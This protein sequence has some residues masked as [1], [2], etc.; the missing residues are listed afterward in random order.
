MTLIAWYH[1][2]KSQLLQRRGI[3]RSYFMRRA[4]KEKKNFNDTDSKKEN[5]IDEQR[6]AIDKLSSVNL[7]VKFKGPGR[8]GLERRMIGCNLCLF[9]KA[10][11]ANPEC[12]W[13]NN[14]SISTLPKCPLNL[15]RFS[16]LQHLRRYAGGTTLKSGA[17]TYCML[18]TEKVR[19]NY[20]NEVR[21]EER[22]SFSF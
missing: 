13:K 17:A 21:L 18:T 14:K 16:Q 20:L 1:Y 15:G 12:H 7:T 8:R 19:N 6:S 3:T 11:N 2:D 9:L 5:S 22:H 4:K 10:W